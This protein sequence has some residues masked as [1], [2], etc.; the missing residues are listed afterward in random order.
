MHYHQQSHTKPV[1]AAE[2]DSHVGPPHSSSPE[3]RVQL[4][5]VWLCIM[6]PPTILQ[7]VCFIRPT[8]ENVTLLK[9]EL[10]QPRYQS[11][12]LCEHLHAEKR[13]HLHSFTQQHNTCGA[14]L[15]IIINRQWLKNAQPPDA[16]RGWSGLERMAEAELLHHA[17]PTAHLGPK[18]HW[19]RWLAIMSL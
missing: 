19:L 6:L 8:R 15:S 3:A 5:H 2:F 4:L 1:G 11:Y 7:A 9:R 12:H 18:H 17:A 16:V 14:Q 10:R 13:R